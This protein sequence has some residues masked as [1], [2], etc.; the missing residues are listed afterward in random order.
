MSKTS[1][2]FYFFVDAITVL[3]SVA[4]IAIGLLW[5]TRMAIKRGWIA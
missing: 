3:G 4:V 5:L 1:G 2:T